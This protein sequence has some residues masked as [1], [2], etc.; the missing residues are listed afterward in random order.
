MFC[1]EPGAAL[2]S[3]PRPPGT[4]DSL[5][6]G[7]GGNGLE[8]IHAYGSKKSPRLGAV[9]LGG[10]NSAEQAAEGGDG[11]DYWSRR[12]TCTASLSAALCE[13]S[14]YAGVRTRAEHCVVCASMAALFL[15]R[16]V[17]NRGTSRPGVRRSRFGEFGDRS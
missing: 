13:W 15:A 6:P 10:S 2:V 7:L 14:M 8:M 11:S 5:R 3:D 17:L 12:R 9:G 4:E 16:R 1:E